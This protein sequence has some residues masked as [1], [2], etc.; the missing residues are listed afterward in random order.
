MRFL[1]VAL[2][3]PVQRTVLG[4][5][6]EPAIDFRQERGVWRMFAESQMDRLVGDKR[7]QGDNPVLHAGAANHCQAHIVARDEIIDPA[8]VQFSEIVCSIADGFGF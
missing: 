4:K 6:G 7:L 1:Y 3:N 2:E 8:Q 5:L